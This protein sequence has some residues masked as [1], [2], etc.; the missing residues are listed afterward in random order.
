MAMKCPSCG[1]ENSDTS[2]YCQNCANPLEPIQKA[3]G[4]LDSRNHT[5]LIVAVAIVS[6]VVILASL[7][8]VFYVIPP[9][10]I[11]VWVVPGLAHNPGGVTDYA[12]YNGSINVHGTMHNSGSEEAYPVLSYTIADSRGWS[13]NDTRSQG[14]VPA[15]GTLDF[16]W[17]YTWPR[18][19]NG[20][21]L[22]WSFDPYFTAFNVSLA[23]A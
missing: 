15:G 8:G 2:T 18:T 16:D 14:R 13:V 7:V 3:P 10:T 9:R 5:R 11:V 12:T 20:I 17:E 22:N 1:A 21:T 6:A 19:Y 4:D 23:A